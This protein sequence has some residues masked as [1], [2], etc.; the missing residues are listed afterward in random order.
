MTDATTDTVDLDG[1]QRWLAER[2]DVVGSLSAKL[3]T[4]GRSNLTYLLEDGGGR[5]FVLR[6]PPKGELLPGAHDM[7]REYRVVEALHSGPVPVPEPIGFCD[8]TSV[9]GAAFAV[10]SFVDGIT[11]R[12]PEDVDALAPRGRAALTSTF[13]ATLAELH[14]VEPA[15]TGRDPARGTDYVARQLHTW[16]RQLDAAPGRELPEMRTLGISLAQRAPRQRSV[17]VVHGD[18]RLDNVLVDTEGAVLAVLDWE[19]WTLG[20]RLADIGFALC[21]WIEPCDEL[22]PLGTSPG[23]G[24]RTQF[25]DAYVTASDAEF[26]AADIDCYLAF[27]TWRFAAILEGVHRRNLSGAYGEGGDE[28]WRRFEHVVPALAERSAEHLARV[29]GT[30]GLRS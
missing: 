20:D 4:G 29:D 24:G 8:D 12:T 11:L 16:Q 1:V 27:G 26:D 2:T 14:G 10:T 19:L 6:R 13:A 18:Y 7:G 15:I 17:A 30:R 23:L 5:R 28:D 25:V 9:I 3:I 22:V 21:Y